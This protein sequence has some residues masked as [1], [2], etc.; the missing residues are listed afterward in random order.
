MGEERGDACLRRNPAKVE[1][2]YYCL[3]LE[4]GGTDTL[5]KFTNMP[6]IDRLSQPRFALDFLDTN[7]PEVN[8][9]K[10]ADACIDTCC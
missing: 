2:G 8:E 7:Q 10:P 3:S 1:T 5:S 4:N 6:H 9:E